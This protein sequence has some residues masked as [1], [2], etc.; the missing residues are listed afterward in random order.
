MGK[1]RG[2]GKEIVIVKNDIT[3]SKLVPI[4]KKSKSLFGC[5]QGQVITEGDIVSPLDVDWDANAVIL[6]DARPLIWLDQ[7]SK[8]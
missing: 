3:A 1:V 5:H 8:K 7:G 2:T 4:K 6:Q